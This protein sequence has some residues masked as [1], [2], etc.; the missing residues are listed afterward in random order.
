VECE[1]VGFQVNVPVERVGAVH[2]AIKVCALLLVGQ[3][4]VLG[5]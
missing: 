1:R 4:A 5:P 3:R 2:L